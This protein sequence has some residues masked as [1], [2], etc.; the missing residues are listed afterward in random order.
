MDRNQADLAFVEIIETWLR[1]ELAGE[2]GG[3]LAE[4]VLQDPGETLGLIHKILG[5]LRGRRALIVDAP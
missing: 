5:H 4:M 2:T 3:L 1:E